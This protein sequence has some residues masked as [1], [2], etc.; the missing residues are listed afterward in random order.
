MLLVVMIMLRLRREF[1][2]TTLMLGRARMTKAGYKPLVRFYLQLTP[3]S[4]PPTTTTHN[5]SLQHPPL[6][7]R[8]PSRAPS[9]HAGS[10]PPRLASILPCSSA[11]LDSRLPHAFTS[12]STFFLRSSPFPDSPTSSAISERLRAPNHETLRN[13][14][15]RSSVAL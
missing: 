6:H 10:L 13:N 15:L 5:L 14:Q 7:H 9:S 3:T 2:F 11:V 4:P 12:S 1:P 8:T